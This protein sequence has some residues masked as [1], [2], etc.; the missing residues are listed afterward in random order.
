M[1]ELN[2][3]FWKIIADSWSKSEASLEDIGILLRDR[4]RTVGAGTLKG[5]LLIDDDDDDDDEIVAFVLKN[6]KG[7]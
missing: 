6:K 5:S 3:G 4:G 1:P 2:I 7:R